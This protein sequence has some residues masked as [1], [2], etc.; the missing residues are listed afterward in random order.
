[1]ARLELVQLRDRF[2]TQPKVELL[3]PSPIVSE[4]TCRKKWFEGVASFVE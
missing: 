2:L 4:K 3:N 1:M